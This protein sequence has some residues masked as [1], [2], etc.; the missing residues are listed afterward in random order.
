MDC[1][2]S[3]NILDHIG[4]TSFV[5]ANY[6]G[7]SFQSSFAN[8]QRCM[9]KI[10]RSIFQDLKFSPSVSNAFSLTKTKLPLNEIL[11]L[12]FKR[13]LPIER[14]SNIFRYRF[15]NPPLNISI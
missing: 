5:I 1:F 15:E 14:R 4:T 13:V 11:L 9:N 6:F 12:V 10:S 7:R 3:F 2:L 8:S